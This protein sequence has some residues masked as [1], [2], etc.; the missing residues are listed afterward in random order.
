MKNLFT[1]LI[2][3]TYIVSYAQSAFLV[4]VV[5][6]D[7]LFYKQT[8]E[9]TFVNTHIDKYK[10][11][12]FTRLE[13]LDSVKNE[14]VTD[15]A[16]SY[17]EALNTSNRILNLLQ[18]HQNKIDEKLGNLAQQYS[19]KVERIELN[20]ISYLNNIVYLRY[21]IQYNEVNDGSRMYL[22]MYYAY[23]TK[24]GDIVSQDEIRS[25]TN[26]KKLFNA[27]SKKWN[28]LSKQLKFDENSAFIDQLFLKPREV[29]DSTQSILVL[30]QVSSTLDSMQLENVEM[31]WTGAGIMVHLKHALFSYKT[32][33]FIDV[34]IHLDVNEIP[35]GCFKRSVFPKSY[36][37]HLKQTN[38]EG[39]KSLL[40]I[41]PINSH[42]TES[43][44]DLLKIDFKNIKE[45]DF[46][47]KQFE[48]SEP[49]LTKRWFYKKGKLTKR[50]YNPNN[51]KY[52]IDSVLWNKDVFT[53][54]VQTQVNKNDRKQTFITC[55]TWDENDN[56]LAS[57]RAYQ[58]IN[59]KRSVFLGDVIASFTYD[60]FENSKSN[61]RLYVNW[62]SKNKKGWTY[63]TSR[64]GKPQVYITKSEGSHIIG[65][66]TLLYNSRGQIVQD[67]RE[68][69]SFLL[70]GYDKENRLN[71]VMS[72]TSGSNTEYQYKYNNVSNISTI[73]KK[74]KHDK[75]W[76]KYMLLWK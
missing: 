23:N 40:S 38:T 56:I 63:T 20:P 15:S 55:L 70:Y 61:E 26:T 72:R 13:L 50:I 21:S 53:G 75:E 28:K 71:E 52:K 35:K 8:G 66:R 51:E 44:I 1:H 14:L 7:T 59:I 4:D 74:G 54:Y 18:T 73:L 33:Q 22:N 42:F 41:Y 47:F 46:T 16:L 19:F 62:Y 57:Y 27:L 68:R 30:P 5:N 3:F 29:N 10:D 45:M 60:V 31:Y 25:G 24:T 39:F 43:H 32:N 58:N 2:F 17:F 34:R 48:T 12:D 76:Q 6:S 36:P 67:W 11:I 37:K 69:Y 64:D 65:E 49:Q 9:P